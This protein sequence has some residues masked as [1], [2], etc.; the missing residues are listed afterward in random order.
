[1]I[2]IALPKGRLME[3]SIEILKNSGIEVET[4]TSRR[5]FFFDKG[6][7]Y[8]F[9]IVRAQDVATYVEHNAAD[10]GIV[11]KDVLNESKPDV[12]ELLDLGIG[13]CRMVVAGRDNECLHKK[14]SSVR[15]A[16]KFVNIAKEHFLKKGINAEIIKLYGSIELA[17]IL[18]IAD[19]IVDIVSTGKTLKENGLSIIE[20]IFESTAILVSNR[21]SYYTKNPKIREFLEHIR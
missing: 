21:I 5:L 17:P 1:M 6:N 12:F 8:R 13:Y 14:N 7:R 3:E 11:G 10:L 19:C 15:V 9:L 20:E 18:G 2:T 16:T 4:P